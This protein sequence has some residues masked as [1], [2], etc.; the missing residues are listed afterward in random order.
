MERQEAK[1]SYVDDTDPWLK[2]KVIRFVEIWSGQPTIQRYYEQVQ[3]DTFKPHE[4]WDRCLQKLQITIDYDQAELDRVPVNGPLVI[5]ANHPFGVVDGL[6]IGHLTS[7]VRKKFKFLV[8]SVLTQADPRIEDYLLPIDFEETKAAQAINIE[9]RKLA[10]EHLRTGG[11]IVIFPSGG[12]ATAPKGFGS[13]E[14]LPWKRF[15]A[16]IIQRSRATVVPIFFHGQNSPLFQF[17]SRISMNLRLGL[18]IHEMH[19][20]IGKKLKV[21]IGVPIPYEELQH[22]KDREKL[23]LELRRRTLGLGNKK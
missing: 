15:P 3:A 21:S 6:M 12:V 7:L 11:T 2:R 16:S 5:L 8:N 9:T 22:L 1:I 19:N 17:V 4:S 14:D 10:I 20:K 23:T 13:A 18:L